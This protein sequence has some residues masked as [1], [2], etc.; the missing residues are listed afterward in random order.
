MYALRNLAIALLGSM[1]FAAQSQAATVLFEDN[2]DT[3]TF[4]PN[5]NLNATPAGWT[6]FQGTVDIIGRQGAVTSFDLLPG[7]GLYIDMDGSTRHEGGINTNQ[8]FNLGPGTYELSYDLGGS[9]RNNGDNSV[10]A[11]I[12]SGGPNVTF[13]SHTLAAAVGF[14]TFVDTF[15]LS[16][17]LALAQIFFR[18]ATGSS[19][20]QGLLLDNVKLTQLT[21]VPLPAAIWLMLS[22]IA[23]LGAFARR[24]ALAS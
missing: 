11:Y 1:A 18:A 20:N 6:T 2:F 15:T 7:N 8:A 10:E 24:R 9:Q 12:N 13:N 19:D 5:G 21:A 17:P 16:A 14:A 22:G 4:V 3:N 23:G